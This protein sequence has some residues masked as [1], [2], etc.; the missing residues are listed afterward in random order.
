MWK[1]SIGLLEYFFVL[2]NFVG[3]E[4]GVI[5][6]SFCVSIISFFWESFVSICRGCGG[7]LEVV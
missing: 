3:K 2:L 6:C 5:V 7:L 4:I 1:E